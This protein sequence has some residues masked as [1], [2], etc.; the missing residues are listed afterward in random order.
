MRK[1]ERITVLD[2]SD[3]AKPT[4]RHGSSGAFVEELQI[5]LLMLGYDIG[6][7]YADGKFGKGTETAVMAFQQ[8]HGLNP[9]G[10]AGKA[11]WTAIYDSL[12]AEEIIEDS[13]V[14]YTVT[15]EHLT[16]YQAEALK[17]FLVCCV[18][19]W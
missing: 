9:D 6:T 16:A 5:D 12:P 17:G 7:A 13:S 15:I 11:T 3:D 19:L 18:D 10:V 2:F 14:L 4:L 8:A 1:N